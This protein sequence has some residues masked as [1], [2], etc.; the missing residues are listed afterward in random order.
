MITVVKSQFIDEAVDAEQLAGLLSATN[1]KGLPNYRVKRG[2]NVSVADN[3]GTIVRDGKDL[4]VNVHPKVVEKA[5]DEVIQKIFGNDKKNIDTQ[6]KAYGTSK[7]ELV[8]AL[9]NIIAY[10]TIV[11]LEVSNE[12]AKRER[13]KQFDLPMTSKQF[14][15]KLKQQKPFNEKGKI[16]TSAAYELAK[17]MLE[18]LEPEEFDDVVDKINNSDRLFQEIKTFP[19]YE[20]FAETPKKVFAIDD[21]EERHFFD[22]KQSTLK[23]IATKEGAKRKVKGK[24]KDT[25]NAAKNAISRVK[26]KAKNAWGAVKS[27]GQFARGLLA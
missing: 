17:K 16:G 11:G 24:A 2:K 9:K 22:S 8:E 25:Y 13:K 5:Y 4:T 21:D 3:G 27:A 18:L 15:Q 23:G 6:L 26:D 1:S 7:R 10:N 12:K 19:K 14:L 20:I